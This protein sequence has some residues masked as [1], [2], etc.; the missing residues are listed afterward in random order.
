MSN[1]Y[2]G[3]NPGQYN[4]TDVLDS[5]RNVA[6]WQPNP[7]LANDM[8][9][10]VQP[11]GFYPSHPS[12]PQGTP[13]LP[14]GF[15]HPKD[16]LHMAPGERIVDSRLEEPHYLGQRVVDRQI[17]WGVKPYITVEKVVE[18]PQVI[19]KER[20]REVPKPEI[21]ERIIEVP[22]TIYEEKVVEVPEYR[23]E[24]QIVEVP[25]VVIEDQI[26]HVVK[27]EIQERI[28]EVPKIE[29]RERIEYDDRVEY[30][31]VPT[32]KIVEVPEIEYRVKEVD[33]FV[34]Q[35][36]VEEFQVDKYVPVNITQVQEVER[37]EHVPLVQ[38][39]QVPKMRPV[40]VP[41]YR[42]I[43]DTADPQRVPTAHQKVVQV[44]YP[45][46][47]VKVMQPPNYVNYDPRVLPAPAPQVPGVPL[48]PT[49]IMH[50]GPHT[51]PMPPPGP[52]GPPSMVELHGP[53][54]SE[55]VVGHRH[56]VLH[57]HRHVHGEDHHGVPAH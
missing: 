10:P 45:Q 11:H 26:V 21:V 24:E 57:G 18:V 29:Y 17:E 14:P 38:Y 5:L 47:A 12:Q 51:P 8:H 53:V 30:R 9:P 44:A 2:S 46:P 27:M 28:I 32:D 42:Q 19:V 49:P 22:K 6:G 52:P 35:Q 37:L 34:P 4:N 54:V 48:A 40:P 50:F 3:L 31:E 55:Q 33:V 20:T 13:Q 25:Q 1:P 41:T 56:Q 7:T 23:I 39:R 43:Y 36:Y 15:M 16:V